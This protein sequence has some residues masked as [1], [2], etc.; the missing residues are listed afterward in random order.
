MLT[1]YSNTI[2]VTT[3]APSL[4]LDLYPSAAAAYSVRLLRSAYTGSAIR[5]R[6][7]S[8]NTESDIGFTALGNLDTTAL[9]SFCG[10]GNGFVTTWYDQSGNSQNV[11]Q[12]TAVLQPQI[13]SSGSVLIQNGKPCIQFNSSTLVAS[14]NNPFSFTGAISL[15]HAS[16]KNSSTY[17][18]YET[19][20]SAGA[21]F[22]N[23]NDTIAF[24]F[25]NSGTTSPQPTFVT[26]IWQPSGVQY[27]G[28]ITTNISYILGYYLSNIST[29]KS[30]GVSNFTLNGSDVATK[31]YGS[32]SPI[33]L[34]TSPIRIGLYDPI[35][36]SSY[37]GGSIHEIISYASDQN[38]NRIGIQTNINTYYGIY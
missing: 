11:T 3:L 34:K 38:S 9:T 21:N 25:G 13:V 6:R 15:I 28:T 4:L 17:L 7:S 12:S 14:I 2:S 36:P 27:D 16:Y 1:G 22:P 37:F 35:L 8:D 33:G 10:A 19:I 5:V 18:S 32:S 31:N 26:D 20:L 24:G 30:G 23:G 29:Q